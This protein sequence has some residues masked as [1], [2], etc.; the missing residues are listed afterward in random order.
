MTVERFI[1]DSILAGVAIALGCTVYLCSV[2]KIVGAFLFSV[3]LMVVCSRKLLLYTGYIPYVSNLNMFLRALIIWLGNCLGV[4][5]TAIVV[6]LAKPDLSIIAD[7]AA[8]IKIDKGLC[9]IPLGILCNVL[10]Y[11]AVDGFKHSKHEVGK[12]LVLVL[13]VMT[14][15][16]C[17]FEHCIANTFYLALGGKLLTVTGLGYII[18]NTFGNTLGGIIIYRLSKYN[19]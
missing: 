18:L 15:I 11:L 17:G 8:T 19:S 4:V 2:N 5:I 12:Y 7:Q 14:F 16:I 13:C 6:Y 1:K 3:G 9:V 10:I